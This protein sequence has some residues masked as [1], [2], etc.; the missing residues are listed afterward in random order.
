MPTM[1]V[2]VT[3]GSKV[4]CVTGRL[5]KFGRKNTYG[6]IITRDSFVLKELEGPQVML[7]E[8][9]LAT[10]IGVWEKVWLGRD[11]L[12]GS[13]VITNPKMAMMTGVL[14]K[15]GH[16]LRLSVAYAT[17]HSGTWRRWASRFRPLWLAQIIHAVVVKSVP[18]E[19][20]VVTDASLDEISVTNRPAVP[21]TRLRLGKLRDIN[22]E[23]AKMYAGLIHAAIMHFVQVSMRGAQVVTIKD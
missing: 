14:G 9:D 19:T 22:K 18:T 21:G 13:G 16:S 20:L 23:E 12:Y 6:E 3:I 4:Q 15:F 8:H 7:F 11:G 1:D 2:E 17:P 5:V 10:P